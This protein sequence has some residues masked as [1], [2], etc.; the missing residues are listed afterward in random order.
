MT[1]KNCNFQIIDG[2]STYRFVTGFYGLTVMPAEFQKVMDNILA[3]FR[4]VFVFIDEILIVT[5]GAKNE[6]MSKMRE[7]P[8]NTGCGKSTNESRKVYICTK[9]N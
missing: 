1:T 2:E 3:R 7:S 8:Q 9:P 5:K 6:H 4:E